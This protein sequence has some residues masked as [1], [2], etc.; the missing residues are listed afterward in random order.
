V[1]LI[2]GSVAL[3][4]ALFLSLVPAAPASAWQPDPDRDAFAVDRRGVDP[5][6]TGRF[7]ADAALGPRAIRSAVLDADPAWTA[8]VRRNPGWVAGWNPANHRLM[9]ATGPATALGGR[10]TAGGRGADGRLDAASLERLTRNVLATSL[11]PW[12]PPDADLDFV[13]AIP[14]GDR[15]W[16][17]FAQ[18]TAGVP[19]WNA[20]VTLHVL[21]DG[22]VNR[23]VN[24]A[25]PDA[26]IDPNPSI[27]PEAAARIAGQDLPPEA[28]LSAEPELAILPIERGRTTEYRLTWKA[29]WRTMTPAGRWLSF[30]DARSGELLWRFNAGH[31]A[32]LTGHVTGDIEPVTQGDPVVETPLRHLN[33]VASGGGLATPAILTTG[34]DGGYALVTP[35]PVGRQLTAVLGGPFGAIFDAANS[36]QTPTIT[37]PVPDTDPLD[38]PIHLTPGQLILPGMDAFHHAM[39]SHDYVKALD[40]ALSVIDFAPPI[41]VNFPASGACNAFWNGTQLVF[42]TAGNNCANSARVATVVMHEYG[43]LV[44]DMQYRPFF[45]S[46]AM[47][48]G[49]SDYLA[50]TM[51][52]QPILGPGWRPGQV[53]D[54]IRRIDVDRVAPDDLSGETHNDGLVIASTL[55]DLR[56]IHG[57]ALVDSLW[58]YARYGYADNF[59]D[60]FV[61]F[62]LTDDDNGNIYDGTPHFTSVTGRFRAHGIGDYAIHVSH[63]PEPDTEDLSKTFP[64]TASFLS[65]FPLTPGS[66]RIHLEIEAN[67]G[68]MPFEF[69]MT[70][71]D[72]T[73]EYV[74]LLGAQPAGTEVRYWFSASDTSGGTVLWPPEG[75]AD[76]FRFR[77]GTDV[78]PPAIAHRAL[79]DQPIDDDS[80][81]VAAV[82]TDNLDRGV[83]AVRLLY[84][85]NGADS[86]NVAM[87]G[88]PPDY[89]AGLPVDGLAVGDLFEYRIEAA[90]S[91]LTP[92]LGAFPQAGWRP[93]HVVNGYGRDFEADQGGAVG[94]GDWEWG[95]PGFGLVP[96]SGQ[97][98]WGTVLNGAYHDNLASTLEFA[99]A[100]LAGFTH[101]TL[102]FWHHL[103]AEP[104]FDGGLIEVSADNGATWEILTP[105]GGYPFERIDASGLPGFSGSIDGWRP[106]EAS[107]AAYAGTALLRIRLRFFADGGVTGPGWFVDDVK[108]VDRTAR[109]RPAG[110]MATPTMTGHV[111]LTWGMPPGYQEAPAGPVL[112]YHVDRATMPAG[113]RVR[114]TGMPLTVRQFEEDGLPDGSSWRYWVTAV[115]A[116][117]ESEPAGPTVAT[118][119]RPVFAGDWTMM[120]AV[121]D[122]GSVIDTV[123]VVRN[124][125]TG[126]LRVNAWPALPGQTLDDVRRR[127]TLVP[128]DT[129]WDTLL[130]DGSESDTL[131]ADLKRIEVRQTADSLLVRLTAW[132]PWGDPTSDFALAIELDLD[133]DVSTGPRGEV[134][135][136]IGARTLALVGQMSGLFVLAS[137]SG[138]IHAGP[139]ATFSVA[140]GDTTAILGFDKTG[141]QAP[142]VV[143]LVARVYDGASALT[144]DR[145]P[146]AVSYPWLLLGP[147]H[148]EIDSGMAANLAMSLGNAALPPG[149]NAGALL[150]ETTDPGNPEVVLPLSLT[151]DND[152]PVVFGT[153]AAL[154][155]PGGLELRWTTTSAVDHLGFQLVRRTT[156]PIVTEEVAVGPELLR[157]GSDG[158]TYRV[159]DVGVQPGFSYAYRLADVSRS[160][161]LTWHGPFAVTAPGA[162][163]PA[164]L[165]LSPAR[166]NPA[167]GATSIAWALPAAGPVDLVIFS[168][169]G[170][171][172]RHLLDRSV[173]EAGWH[174]T[175]WDGRDDAGS[176][177]PSGVYFYRLVGAGTTVSRKML[178]MR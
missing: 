51:T 41:I 40:P 158:A 176:T 44:T 23:V 131:A 150:L 123:L 108:V 77:V 119:I 72:G 174:D 159:V 157:P 8:L 76:P 129:G 69:A 134:F 107:L 120:D 136:M 55:W 172:V 97:K 65:I 142:P 29:E 13:R 84:R 33:L 68:T 104:F 64:L 9:S 115:Y 114:L 62:L 30:V 2:T 105:D 140:A 100:N 81:V 125:G 38:N 74:Y 66:V 14:V 94:G 152:V 5:A 60:Y 144:A 169:D 109:L 80:R 166:P 45:P 160:G 171:A 161:T 24:R 110:L 154:P 164:T 143:G 85:R 147:R 28:E 47:H 54:Y 26:T 135:G 156:A 153:F 49:F 7:G 91:A 137:E 155:A 20:R 10:A 88:T 148:L 95:V 27:A 56:E 133:D 43:H 53:P 163:V 19:V 18:R 4:S 37:L 31:A 170:R 146:D 42:F 82:V 1:R 22:R 106:V 175:A 117:G 34:V 32:E 6:A 92:N 90:D 103:D 101:G 83:G 96:P 21:A 145:S 126:A 99:P 173:H 87:T 58:H 50:C 71:A 167:P 162:A 70:P 130:V 63:A 98:V 151:I 149:S 61:D 168:V 12:L 177:V 48:E 121:V 79:D 138:Y 165:Q 39:L 178:L 139:L 52:N 127:L 86:T 25:H 118:R 17:H 116:G 15:W 112:G 102:S 93:F 57:A 67:G 113:E 75:D 128:F 36:F 89:R 59:D 141:G 35:N 73:R 124:D 111:T 132:R 16:V 11:A 78:L 3:L 122:S 46:G